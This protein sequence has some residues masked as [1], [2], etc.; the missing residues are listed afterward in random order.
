[1]ARS[2]RPG[3]QP[4]FPQR[5]ATKRQANS[6]SVPPTN[7]AKF[8]IRQAERDAA[9]AVW[10]RLSPRQQQRLAWET[11]S[12][13]AHE[14]GLAYPSVVAVGAGY[15]VK[16]EPTRESRKRRAR[17]MKIE[18]TGEPCVILT[19]T[20]KWKK[21]PSA[22]TV[23]PRRGEIPKCFI[24]YAEDP[25][26]PQRRV[27]VAVPTD[28]R[29]RE[30]G[31]ARPRAGDRG[32]IV[33]R[34][35]GFDSHRG[36]LACIV[37][38]PGRDGLFGIGAHHVLAMSIADGIPVDAAD[39]VLRSN[40]SY[41]GRL[42]ES[43]IGSIRP[44]Q[45]AFDAALAEIHTGVGLPALRRA[46]GNMTATDYWNDPGAFP[47]E[48]LVLVGP[49]ETQLKARFVQRRVIFGDTRDEVVY[50]RGRGLQ[51][52]HPVMLEFHVSENE[53]R[54]TLAGESGCPI[55]TADR[56]TLVAMH[57][58]GVDPPSRIIWAIPSTE[59]FLPSRWNLPL[60][61][62]LVPL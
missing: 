30:P 15:R 36:I 33:A 61:P 6:R 4:K 48:C 29:E 40:N 58:G 13:R 26:D 12:S 51:P 19:V 49:P 43:P 8:Q 31:R 9:Q 24:A 10:I 7:P 42:A 56:S 54:S 11:A 18:I 45:I 39:I 41:I 57:I 59:L 44:G 14:L 35:A 62:V 47:E 32:L 38:L 50:F 5:Q 3:K 27:A 52:L 17:S 1:M 55:V 25:D 23:K 28:V 21:K 2:P 60:A 46:T 37:K 22:T 34:R 20:R 53:R 16:N